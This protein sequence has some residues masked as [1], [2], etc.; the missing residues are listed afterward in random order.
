MKVFITGMGGSGKSAIISE[1][2]QKGYKAIDLDKTDLCYWIKKTTGE[3][4]ILSYR[5]LDGNR[6]L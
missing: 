2:S 3:R 4:K 1:L 6:F 5:V